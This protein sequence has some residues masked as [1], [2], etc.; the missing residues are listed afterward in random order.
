LEKDKTVR[1]GKHNDKQK[2]REDYA[3][4]D[5]VIYED[6]VKDYVKEQDGY[7][8]KQDEQ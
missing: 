7:A 2:A 3:N 8:V 5:G 6:Y 1:T 4:N